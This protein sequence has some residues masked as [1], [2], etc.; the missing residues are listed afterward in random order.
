V[1]P[2]SNCFDAK[3][4]RADIQLTDDD[5][6]RLRSPLAWL[7][8]AG[9][10]LA[11]ASDPAAA[12]IDANDVIEHLRATIGDHIVE[13]ALAADPGL[14]RASGPAPNAVLQIW[15]FAGEGDDTEDRD[16]LLASGRLWSADVLLPALRVDD[17][18]NPV[19]VREVKCRFDRWVKAAGGGRMRA[20][21]LPLG[22]RGCYFLA[23][24]AAP[25]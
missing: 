13:A 1:S 5:E 8:D 9:V 15:P 16:V 19:P 14:P 23:A 24:V 25:L 11:P 20:V 22:E 18:D 7:Q 21:L 3:L 10:L 2:F 17:P 12:R 6:G 4:F